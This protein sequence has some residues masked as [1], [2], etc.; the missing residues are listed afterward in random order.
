MSSLPTI[1]NL[2]LTLTLAV[3]ENDETQVR[4]LL[5]L[6]TC[7]HLDDMV[8]MACRHSVSAGI[9]EALLAHGGQASTAD[10]EMWGTA[11]LHEAAAQG[12]ADLVRLLL[13]HGANPN[14]E[15][16]TCETPLAE[17]L[18]ADVVQA[19]VE[20]GAELNV[21]DRQGNV[22]IARMKSREALVA[23]LDLGADPFMLSAWPRVG[24]IGTNPECL[25]EIEV[26]QQRMLAAARRDQLA[27]MARPTAR[28]PELARR[29]M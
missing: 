15:T 24:Y 18:T 1:T 14:Q 21:R 16:D 6:G 9:L 23:A 22:P 25:V 7:N 8:L 10:P 4:R 17:A 26:A 13:A 28:E 5:A 2:D 19:L 27:S 12:R 11:P 3:R 20:G 29:A